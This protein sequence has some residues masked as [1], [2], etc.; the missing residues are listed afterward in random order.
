[1]VHS[2]L[3]SLGTVVGG[4][5]TV[6]HALMEVLTPEG[7]LMMPSFN[8]GQAFKPGQPGIFDPRTTPTTNG[9]IPQVFWQ[10]DG[11]LRSLNPTHSFA[12]WGK[13]ARAY[14]QGHHHTLTCGPDS[15]LGLL[16]RAGGHGLL[17]GVD[18]RSNTFHHVV[19]TMLAAPCLEQNGVALPMRL[20]DGRIVEGRTW[21]W[22]PRSCPIND[23]ALYGP[24]IEQ[25]GL[26]QRT[27]IGRG[28]VRRFRLMSVFPVIARCLREGLGGHPPCHECPIRP[29]PVPLPAVPEACGNR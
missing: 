15:P 23:A 1:M 20:P 25:Q 3:K 8:H 5:A 17:I 6:I 7:T 2:S 14:T 28:L 22:R 29:Q 26:E 10:M 13:Q 9:A 24:L 18:Y 19:E 12:A 4:P 27:V 16:A 21:K 11:V